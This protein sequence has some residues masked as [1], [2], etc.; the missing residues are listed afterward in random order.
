M[1]RTQYFRAKL[2]NFGVFFHYLLAL[3]L[4]VVAVSAAFSDDGA[5]EHD[6][7]LH[8]FSPGIGAT[9]PQGPFHTST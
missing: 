5:A 7:S 6:A 2:A 3:V 8:R 1:H 4:L 9:S